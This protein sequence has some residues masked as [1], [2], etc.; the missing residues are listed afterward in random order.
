[1]RFSTYCA[2]KHSFLEALERLKLLIFRAK[3][4]FGAFLLIS[5]AKIAEA[6]VS[7]P[8]YW[9]EPAGSAQ[10]QLQVDW[11]TCHF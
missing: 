11:T 3:P 5:H 10:G 4:G 6:S 8:A 1:M 7:L 9:T 2:L